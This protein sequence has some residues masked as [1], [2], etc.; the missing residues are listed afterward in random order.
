MLHGARLSTELWHETDGLYYDFDL[1]NAHLIQ[2]STV[3]ALMPLYA[4]LI[5]QDRANRLVKDHLL[6][7]D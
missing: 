7:S 5:D 4:G 3:A 2:H 1:R 6:N